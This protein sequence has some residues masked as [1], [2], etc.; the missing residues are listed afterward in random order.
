MMTVATKNDTEYVNTCKLVNRVTNHENLP[1]SHKVSLS[2]TNI[3]A[4][5]SSLPKNELWSVLTARW[6]KEEC[7]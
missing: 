6:E 4:N 5:F 7:Y 3:R 2:S 1:P